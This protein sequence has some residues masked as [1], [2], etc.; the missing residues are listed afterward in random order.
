MTKNDLN[1]LE[2]D[3]WHELDSR[4]GK[5]SELSEF[6]DVGNTI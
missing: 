4:T 1:A 3:F 2:M 5:E 6:S